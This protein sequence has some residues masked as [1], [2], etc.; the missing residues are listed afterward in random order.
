MQVQISRDVHEVFAFQAGADAKGAADCQE[1]IQTEDRLC[2]QMERSK[3][4]R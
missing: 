2:L 4:I 3:K 1:K